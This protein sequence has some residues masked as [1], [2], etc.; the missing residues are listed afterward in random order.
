MIV[1]VSVQ[2]PAFYG[3]FN[4]Q[5]LSN[6]NGLELTAVFVTARVS[7]CHLNSR[8]TVIGRTSV[9][10]ECRSRSDEEGSR[11]PP[12]LASMLPRMSVAPAPP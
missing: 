6:D 12:T 7:C 5:T 11:S 2:V 4:V 8:W 10:T 3:L 1:D 9:Y